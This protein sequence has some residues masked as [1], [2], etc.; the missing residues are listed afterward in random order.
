MKKLRKVV[1]VLVVV[2]GGVTGWLYATGRI[3]GTH[4]PPRELTLYGNVDVRQVELGF[5][6]AGRLQ[7]MH[8]EEGQAVEAG[9]VLASLD[10]R[11]FEDQ[12]RGAQAQVAVQQATLDKLVAG[13]R[14][15]EVA[16]AKAAV[17]EN[18]AAKGYA[19]TELERT[20][21]LV[22]ARALPGADLDTARAN[23]RQADARLTSV[24]ES[25]RLIVQ[26]SRGEDIA[27]GRATLQVAQA[28]LASVQTALDDTRLLAPSA[29]VVTS[30]VREPGAIV[31]PNDTVYVIALTQT[32]WVRA[33]VSE[34][35]LGKL[36]PGMEIA[37]RSD[38][39]PQH[40]YRGHVGF[41][42]PT[43]EFTPKSVETPELRT[44]LVYRLHVVV[45]GP[46]PGLR[47]GMP[48][49]VVVTTSGA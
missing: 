35:A 7:T 17:E 12:L 23:S 34:A 8:F 31:S 20:R 46:A 29:G 13:S 41:I 19:D 33:Y 43:A 5:R 4:E 30:R 32:V 18:R 40:P 25:L 22:D 16:R 3:G 47:Q 21:K 15:A 10:A 36:H 1:A 42:S 9:A 26:G 2:A 45:D 37:V 24:Q 39:E 49:T 38:T 48:V 14:P 44:A 11:P 27:A 28:N 6:A